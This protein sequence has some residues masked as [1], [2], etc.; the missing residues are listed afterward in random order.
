MDA[1]RRLSVFALDRGPVAPPV[2]WL[3]VRDGRVPCP[4]RGDIDVDECVECERQI[5]AAESG[6][7]LQIM[8][9]DRAATPRAR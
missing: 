9:G 5:D 6:G 2:T 7:V 8:C 3:A 1:S 4:V